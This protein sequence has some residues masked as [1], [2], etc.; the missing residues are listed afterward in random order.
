LTHAASAI[1]VATQTPQDLASRGWD[2]R[3][4]EDIEATKAWLEHL[5]GK[6]GHLVIHL[7]PPCSTFSRAWNRSARTRL[8]TAAQPQGLEPLSAKVLDANVIAKASA[9]LAA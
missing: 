6:H 8:R 2:F 9:E 7:A 5:A 4:E 3:R 1:G